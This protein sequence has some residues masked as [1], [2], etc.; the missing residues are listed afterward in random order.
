M[1]DLVRGSDDL[2]P[3]VGRQ[4]ALREH[5]ADVVVQDLGCRARDRPQ[6]VLPALS[7]EL[8]ERDAELRRAVQDLHRAERVDVDARDAAP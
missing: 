5:P 3:G 2:L 6:P 8:P 1:P 4:L 7:E